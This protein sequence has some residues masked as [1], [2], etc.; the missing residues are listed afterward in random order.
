MDCFDAAL[1]ELNELIDVA[2]TGNVKNLAFVRR[3]A[4]RIIQGLRLLSISTENCPVC[5][6][7]ER[8]ERRT[9][10][11]RERAP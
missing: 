2:E 1:A 3:E 8:A 4:A 10:E 6:L 7:R 5:K 9:A 11:I